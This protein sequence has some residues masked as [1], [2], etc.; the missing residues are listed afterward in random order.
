MPGKIVMIPD[1]SVMNKSTDTS[2]RCKRN[3]CRSVAVVLMLLA[4]CAV[5][6][7][8][9]TSMVDSDVLPVQAIDGYQGLRGRT[10]QWGG[11]IVEITNGEKVTRIQVLSYPLGSDGN[12][13]EYQSPTGRFMIEYPEFL[14]PLDYAPGRYLTAVGIIES[15]AAEKIGESRRKLPVLKSGQ[16]HLWPK[17]RYRNQPQT[18]VGFG[19]RIGL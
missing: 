17:H 13:D 9:D 3:L 4:G 16:V 7:P 10:V 14:E 6:G 18:R 2:L 15:L 19:F 5:T 12:P 11:L 1:S 8:L